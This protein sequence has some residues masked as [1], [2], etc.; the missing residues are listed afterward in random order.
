[1][2]AVGGRCSLLLLSALQLL[3]FSGLCLVSAVL[4]PILRLDLIS[5]ILKVYRTTSDPSRRNSKLQQVR[6]AQHAVH[7]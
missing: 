4:Q 2:S 3:F 6:L 5:V 1:M 7:G